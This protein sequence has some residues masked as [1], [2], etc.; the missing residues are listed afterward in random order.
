[1]K[2]EFSNLKEF[3]DYIPNCLICGKQLIL[4]CCGTY[5]EWAGKNNPT[6]IKFLIKEDR[7]ISLHKNIQLEIDIHTNKVLS[8]DSSN[9]II[10][11][12]RWVLKT[13]KTCHCQIT[14]RVTSFQKPIFSKIRRNTEAVVFY[15]CKN[16]KITVFENDLLINTELVQTAPIELSS[17]KDFK[18]LKRRIQ[19]IL[20]FS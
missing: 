8:G 7:I 1:M 2:S 6:R 14:G 10:D 3:I 4:S 18:H 20:T 13:C 11:N 9:Q 12:S 15:L 17:F 19:T 16:K 5:A